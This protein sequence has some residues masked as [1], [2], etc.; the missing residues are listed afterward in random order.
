MTYTKCLNLQPACT[1]AKEKA[2]SP[3][4]MSAH[5]H[6]FTLVT[7]QNMPLWPYLNIPQTFKHTSTMKWIEKS[8]TLASFTG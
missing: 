8:S 7:L 3:K 5:K 1:Q 2:W 6:E 4:I